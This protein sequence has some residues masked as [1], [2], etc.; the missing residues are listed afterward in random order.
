MMTN[1]P[2]TFRTLL[3]FFLPIEVNIIELIDD[4]TTMKEIDDVLLRNVG[5]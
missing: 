5:K 2:T 3:E 1:I 4:A